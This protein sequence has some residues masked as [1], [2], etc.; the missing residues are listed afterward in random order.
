MTTNSA[1]NLRDIINILKRETSP[2]ESHKH[3][4][5][6]V[7]LENGEGVVR[8]DDFTYSLNWQNVPFYEMDA[9]E[10]LSFA[11]QDLEEDSD[12]GRVNALTNAK[13]AIECRVDECLKSLNFQRFSSQHGWHM[14]YKM[15]VLQTFGI[16]TPS[17]LKRR[18]TSK[19]N[20]LEHEYVRPKNQEE[21][22]DIVEIAELFIEATNKHIMK[23][24]LSSA[25]ITCTAWFEELKTEKVTR[26][27][28][29]RDKYELDFDL[30]NEMLKL[31]H[32]ECELVQEVTPPTMSI[33]E[34]RIG[35]LHKKEVITLNIRDSEMD[36]FRELI[37][38]LKQKEQ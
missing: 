21:V 11:K 30:D 7:L 22:R 33:R 35:Q 24:Y 18:I 10:L 36:D 16:L 15:Q 27:Y 25:T 4:E 32:S 9:H 17:I 13:R 34:Q 14:P 12:R 8:K 37:I 1:L 19:R 6:K 23:G 38:L 2:G 31:T 28:G 5:G 26:Y 29:F 20:L 3:V